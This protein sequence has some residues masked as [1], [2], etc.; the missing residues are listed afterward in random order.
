MKELFDGLHDNGFKAHFQ[1]AILQ[2]DGTQRIINW[3][4][5][6]LHDDQGNVEQ[7]LQD[8]RAI[9]PEG[10]FGL[11]AWIHIALI[12]EKQGETEAAVSTLQE[13]IVK[14]PEEEDGYLYLE[15]RVDD[16][17][18]S[19]GINIMPARVEEVLLSHPDVA[20]AAVIGV[21]DPEW[22]QK[23]K[24]FVISKRAD[25]DDSELDRFMKE[26]ELADYQ[27]PRTYEFAEA[28]PRTATGKVN[29]K[30][31]REER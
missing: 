10:P 26:S 28:L 20:E 8:F 29:R 15:G 14:H 18:I 5:V 4:N 16:M 12:Q 2:K 19:G 24:A 23:V 7:A 3:S 11:E 25:L 9:P 1:N 13:V 21:P 30:A 6:L 31:L 17:I 27:R 22:G